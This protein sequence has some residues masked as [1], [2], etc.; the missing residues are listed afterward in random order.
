M[1]RRYPV[2]L[3]RLLS[4]DDRQEVASFF[5]SL[6]RELEVRVRDSSEHSPFDCAFGWIK[7]RERR[8]FKVDRVEWFRLCSVY[9]QLSPH[10]SLF[11]AAAAKNRDDRTAIELFVA[12]I[13]GLED[14]PAMPN[15]KR[16]AILRME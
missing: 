11:F 16:E 8:E 3:P 5:D 1:L 15:R 7:E 2:S 9:F 13:R 12:G 6:P 10:D 14:W 4:R